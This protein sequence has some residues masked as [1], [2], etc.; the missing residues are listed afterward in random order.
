MYTNARKGYSQLPSSLLRVS[1]QMGI[2]LK[3]YFSSERGAMRTPHDEQPKKKNTYS[4]TIE[5]QRTGFLHSII[6]RHINTMQKQIL[7]FIVP[8]LGATIDIPLSRAEMEGMKDGSMIAKVM[9]K[10]I[11]PAIFDYMARTS[12]TCVICNS[13]RANRMTCNLAPYPNSPEGPVVYAFNPYPVCFSSLCNAESTRRAHED[14]RELSS[15]APDQLGVAESE[16]CDYCK[17]VQNVN[18][19]GR[20]QR[21]SRCKAKL[22]CSKDCQTAD[23]RAGHKLLCF[24]S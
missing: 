21:C 17:K 20:L 4:T 13:N 23:W 14:R 2:S 18:E 6:N 9:T 12:H 22:Y 10:K 11:E 7:K 3:R 24:K 15:L 5:R 1:I 8:D 19:S 16:M